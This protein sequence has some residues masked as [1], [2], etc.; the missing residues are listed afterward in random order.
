MVS[1]ELVVVALM[2][3]GLD[4]TV[5]WDCGTEAKVTVAPGIYVAVQGGRA[6][7]H[8]DVLVRLGHGLERCSHLSHLGPT[9]SKTA[10]RLLR[11]A[12]AANR[13]GNP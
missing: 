3:E 1:A 10:E 4:A 11:A 9:R 8:R 2:I 13:A 5:D 7:V 12:Q 6:V